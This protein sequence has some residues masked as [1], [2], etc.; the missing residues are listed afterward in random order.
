MSLSRIPCSVCL[1][2]LFVGMTSPKAISAPFSTLETGKGSHF[3]VGVSARK[4]GIDFYYTPVTS[5]R[6][7][8]FLATPPGG[9]GDVGLFTISSGPITYENGSIDFGFDPGTASVIINDIRQ[10]SPTDRVATGV[11]RPIFDLTFNSSE[12]AYAETFTDLSATGGASSDEVAAVPYVEWV[13][14]IKED[15]DEFL[16]AVVGYQFLSTGADSGRK[17]V[18]IQSL[19]A[20]TTVYSYRYDFLGIIPPGGASEFPLDSGPAIFD[21]ALATQPGS[22]IGSGPI[23]PT[24]GSTVN[25]VRTPLFAVSRSRLDVDLHEVPIG[26]EWGRRVGKWEVALRGGLTLNA[27]DLD[28]T[29]RTEWY[30]AGTSAPLVST[31]SS[32]SANEFAV[33]AYLGASL[34]Y[35]LNE[36]GSVYV[37]AHGSYH[38]MDS[39]SVTTAGAGADINL[40][41]WEG[42]LGLGFVLD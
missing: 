9:P 16:R 28:L 36:D 30:A 35:P 23:D 19:V 12:T 20:T 7:Q 26:L 32:E 39:I 37:R 33:G 40:S 31:T 6:A 10:L 8:D 27:V 42:G 1:C 5:V 11:F 18:G 22:D 3:R 25:T 38:W 13:I 17:L 24:V 29:T 15:E 4:V 2:A 34:T 41:S 21:V 14:P